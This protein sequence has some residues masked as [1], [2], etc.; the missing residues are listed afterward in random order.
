MR[1]AWPDKIA[2]TGREKVVKPD[3]ENVY[4]SD[5]PLHLKGIMKIKDTV[6]NDLR[7]RPDLAEEVNRQLEMIKG[8]HSAK[9]EIPAKD[10]VFVAVHNRR[11]D[12]LSHMSDL[13]RGGH[14][15]STKYFEV[16]EVK[17]HV[18]IP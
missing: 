3:R 15:M 2:R 9:F 18:F 17:N 4:V 12:Y 10:V 13:Y 7:L 16:S 11:T 1:R 14:S 6:L 8:Q 5:F